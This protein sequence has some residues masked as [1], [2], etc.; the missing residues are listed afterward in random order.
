MTSTKEKSCFKQVMFDGQSHRG[1]TDHC[2]TIGLGRPQSIALANANKKNY[3][4]FT[5]SFRTSDVTV[6]PSMFIALQKTSARLSPAN[7]V[8]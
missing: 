2:G 5:S 6:D 1:A 3:V 8:Y 4:H 7:P